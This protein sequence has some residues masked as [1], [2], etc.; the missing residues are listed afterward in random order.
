VKRNV[1]PDVD[2][3][4]H[5]VKPTETILAGTGSGVQREIMTRAGGVI[6]PQDANPVQTF[7]PLK[8]FDQNGIRWWINK[9]LLWDMGLS[10]EVE[11]NPLRPGE[12]ENSRIYRGLV[13]VDHIPPQRIVSY[14]DQNEYELFQRW[15][16]NRAGTV[17]S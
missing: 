4:H 7:M 1:T 11:V 2:E 9:T 12:G 17:R 5:V 13:I 6:G 14:D 8:D 10:L 16:S 15:L 3:L